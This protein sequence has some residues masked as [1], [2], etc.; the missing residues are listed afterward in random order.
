MA[1]TN[2]QSARLIA[3][4]DALRLLPI[5]TARQHRLLPLKADHQTLV[6]AG[7]G[8]F[9]LDF[10]TRLQFQLGRNLTLVRVPEDIF[11]AA[12]ETH[13][14]SSPVPEA[15]DF[16]ESL[17]TKAPKLTNEQPNNPIDWARQPCRITAVMGAAGGLGATTVAA[18]LAV[19]LAEQNLSV[20][21]IDA[22]F[23]RPTAHIA[24]GAKPTATIQ[25]LHRGKS[26][27]YDSLT[28]T[29]SGVRLLA[30]EPGA[31]DLAHLTYDDL[32]NLG[33]APTQLAP[34]FDHIII[35]LPSTIDNAEL[36]YLKFAH[37]FLL[38]TGTDST[39]LHNSLVIS[40]TGLE[41]NPNLPINILFNQQPKAEVAKS[42]FRKLQVAVDTSQLIFAGALP[43]SKFMAEAWS[44][45][46]PL[47]RLKPRDKWNQNLKSL[48]SQILPNLLTAH[49]AT[50]AINPG[51]QIAAG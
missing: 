4:P 24:L 25:D 30:G 47:A 34:Q 1:Q 3:Q 6:C 51:S 49:T 38:L 10:L 41:A 29:T 37:Q 17:S 7:P 42:A 33:A 14:G 44:C 36:S 40:R 18:N 16:L 19:Q 26:L 2:A 20:L 45:R 22:N 46:T 50:P 11:S 48:Q 21:L 31:A 32:I 5:A 23:S 28:L 39:S 35:D 27:A 43:P 8:P 13:F 9:D 15:T 12:F